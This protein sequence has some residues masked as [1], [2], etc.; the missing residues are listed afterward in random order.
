MKRAD[1]IRHL[2]KQG[3]IFI[4]EGGNHTIYKNPANGRMSV[5]PRHREVKEYLAKKI[6]DDLSVPRP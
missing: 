4:R 5:I 6:C 3:C 1:L 2:E